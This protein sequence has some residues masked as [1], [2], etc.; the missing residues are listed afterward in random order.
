MC[1]QTAHGGSDRGAPPRTAAQGEGT[2]WP[3]DTGGKDRSPSS[4]ALFLK[5]S[6][7][8]CG[9]NKSNKFVASNVKGSE[10][11]LLIHKNKKTL[12]VPS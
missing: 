2:S 9:D 1:R 10:L 3:G 5:T 8:F 4:D 12:I 11:D 6:L 7:C